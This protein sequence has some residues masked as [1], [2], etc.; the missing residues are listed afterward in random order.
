MGL[1]NEIAEKEKEESMI[2]VPTMDTNRKRDGNSLIVNPRSGM[3]VS[4][5]NQFFS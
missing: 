2:G 5:I 4:K 3:V 1:I